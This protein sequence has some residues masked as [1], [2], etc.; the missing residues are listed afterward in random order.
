VRTRQRHGGRLAGRR[1]ALA[2]DAAL[3]LLVGLAVVGD[4]RVPRGAPLRLCHRRARL[5]RRHLADLAV[6]EDPELLLEL[7]VGEPAHR[8]GLELGLGRL[9]EILAVADDRLVEAVL[10][11]HLRHVGLH[12]VQLRER[13]AVGIV[14]ARGREG[15]R[16][17]E[18]HAR[19]ATLHCAAACALAARS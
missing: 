3:E 17:D 11:A 10:D 16:H 8:L 5:G 1:R 2:R 14:R 13:L 12:R 19:P 7:E 6:A 18:R 9:L 4:V 15:R